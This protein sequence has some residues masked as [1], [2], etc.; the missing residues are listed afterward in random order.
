MPLIKGI[1]GGVIGATIGAAMWAAISYYTNYEVGIVAWG[2]GV[3]AGIGVRI[4]AGESLSGT[5]GILAAVIAILGVVGGKY[6]AVSVQ[7]DSF[8]GGGD[9]TLVVSCIADEIVYERESNGGS[10]R[11]P[12]GVNPNN[13][14]GPE[15]YPD[16]IWMEAQHRYDS[17]PVEEQEALKG[18]PFLANPDYV[19]SYLADSVAE[20]W[21][22]QGRQLDWPELD[23]DRTPAREQEYPAQVWQEAENRWQ[24]MTE[25]EHKQFEAGVLAYED[26]LLA[27]M[28]GSVGSQVKRDAFVQSFDLFDLLWLGLAVVSA[29]KLGT[30]QE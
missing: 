23:S 9:R 2:I 17:L 14:Y 26:Q 25:Q 19:F 21:E 24:D 3:L 18:H 11:F 16:H 8:M 13:A 29:W 28:V 30:G 12:T 20:E 27:E 7:I 22:A 15:E 10:V 4:G 1:I 5:T 6:T